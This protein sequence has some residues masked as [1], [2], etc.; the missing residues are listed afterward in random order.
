MKNPADERHVRLDDFES[1]VAGLEFAPEVWAVFA[2]L[3]KARSA[4]EIAP[5]V[6]LKPEVVQKALAELVKAGIIRKQAMGWKEFAARPAPAPAAAAPVPSA[7]AVMAACPAPQALMADGGAPV[8][9]LRVGTRPEARPHV[10]LRVG[11]EPISDGPPWRLRPVLDAISASVG[12]GIPGQ[13]LVV[14]VF[15]QVP[16]DLLKAAGVDSINA[17]PDSLTVRDTRLRAAIIEAS[18]KHANLDVS[19]LAA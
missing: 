6:K 1:R 18:R 14:K 11:A 12:G 10:T 9:S 2:Q 19:A 5:L 16:A 3:D 15:L 17:V 13:L 7:P 4:S 8:V